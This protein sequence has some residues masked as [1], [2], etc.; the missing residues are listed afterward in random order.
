MR[1][2]EIS[3]QGE[4][5][6][7]RKDRW[8]PSERQVIH[9]REDYRST[10]DAQV[11]FTSTGYGGVSYDVMMVPNL[12]PRPPTVRPPKP[13]CL[14]SCCTLLMN[15]LRSCCTFL[16]NG[17]CP[18]CTRLMNCS[19]SCCTCLRNGLC[20][21]CTCLR[22]CCTRLKNC[23]VACFLGLVHYLGLLWGWIVG[24]FGR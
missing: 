4:D 2:G 5:V 15:C 7:T 16:R 20:P 10:P 21:C 24:L 14:C 12:V 1:H 19:R 6:L 18:C 17:L 22:S 3:F 13:D 9:L 8:E 23:C 11:Q